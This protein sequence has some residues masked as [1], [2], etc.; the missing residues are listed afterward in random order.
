MTDQCKYIETCANK[1]STQVNLEMGGGG[2]S[3][4]AE[5]Y[6]TLC[7]LNENECIGGLC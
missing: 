7:T 4:I 6:V 1:I 2:N 5:Y 3:Q